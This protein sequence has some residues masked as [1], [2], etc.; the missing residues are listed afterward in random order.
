MAQKKIFDEFRVKEVPHYSGNRHCTATP[1]TATTGC[2]QLCQA[3]WQ[4]L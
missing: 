4:A 3:I 2:S 1:L